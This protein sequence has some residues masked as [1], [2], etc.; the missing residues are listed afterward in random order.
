[1][2]EVERQENT[3]EE[4]W[5][6]AGSGDVLA[7]VQGS[8]VDVAVVQW[9]SDEATRL[10]TRLRLV[11][12][13]DTGGLMTPYSAL[14]TSS[15]SFTDH[16]KREAEA[17]VAGGA[18]Q[19]S[20]RHPDLVVRTAVLWGLPSG[21][22]VELSKDARRLVIGGSRP[23]HLERLLLGSVA[24][25]V[26]AHARCAAVVVPEGD[27]VG[28]LSHIVVGVDGSSG[29]AVAVE[30]AFETAAAGGS[31]ITCVI[32]WDAKPSSG[33]VVFEQYVEGA[34][35]AEANCLAVAH[36][37][38]DPLAARYPDVHAE[39]V[40]RRGNPADVIVETAAEVSADLVVV[41]SRGHGGFV[42]LLLGS[43]SRRVVDRA[44]SVVVIAH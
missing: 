42:G 17:L 25:P 3:S 35:K 28:A 21:T 1:M 10:G 26:V 29:S 24:V 12:V 39:V 19:A 36:E 14:A 23:T 37:V 38:V 33:V 44:G 27:A 16:L 43:V 6:A 30:M 20:E 5:A 4:E 13:I 15:S 11:H 32:G 2:V 31:D 34:A 22:L 9:A 41:G 18:E 40:V 8:R 7:G